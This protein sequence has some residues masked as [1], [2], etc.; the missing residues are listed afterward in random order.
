MGLSRLGRISMNAANRVIRLPLAG[1]RLITQP[2]MRLLCARGAILQGIEL[3]SISTTLC[4]RHILQHT[5]AGYL[6][7]E[8]V[9]LEHFASH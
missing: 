4:A 2:N 5:Y 8:H 1:R 7:A 3:H 9:N 6:L